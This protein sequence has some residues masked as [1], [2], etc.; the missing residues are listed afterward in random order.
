MLVGFFEAWLHDGRTP[1]ANHELIQDEALLGYL[2]L[3]SHAERF[4]VAHEYAH[5]LEKL[6]L[7]PQGENW[8]VG[9]RR[10]REIRADIFASRVVVESAS[11]LDEAGATVS[12]RGGILAL[13]AH[14]LLDSALAMVR[15]SGAS[16]FSVD[17]LAF[18]ERSAVCREAVQWFWDDQ[19]DPGD[20]CIGV[21]TE[22]QMADIVWQESLPRLEEVL[23][24]RDP[25]PIWR[26]PL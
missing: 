7:L 5:A 13:K 19:R 23:S 24:R 12:L 25:H 3:R 26:N 20:P 8:G 15:H 4:V 21:Q 17:Y 22:A 10:L 18:D 2:L 14:E 9:R 11:N 16:M 1:E 6:D